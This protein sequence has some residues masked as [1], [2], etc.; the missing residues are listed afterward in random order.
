MVRKVNSSS[1]EVCQVKPKEG[2]VMSWSQWVSVQCG[3]WGLVR[4]KFGNSLNG[5][6]T[7]WRIY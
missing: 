4:E 3:V 7:D 5:W 2:E 6:G 1:A